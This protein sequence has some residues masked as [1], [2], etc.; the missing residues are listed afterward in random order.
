MSPRP[1]DELLE[2]RE[3]V[4]PVKWSV[5][6]LVTVLFLSIAFMVWGLGRLLQSLFD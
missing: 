2:W 6:A 1:G 5:S 3:E 4:V